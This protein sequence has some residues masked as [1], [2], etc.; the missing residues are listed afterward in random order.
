MTSF[1]NTITPSTFHGPV[2]LQQIPYASYRS[3]GIDL[4]KAYI[5][6]GGWTAYQ[7]DPVNAQTRFSK[8]KTLAPLEGL[9]INCFGQNINAVTYFCYSKSALR[10]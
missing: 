3:G 8:N 6:K 1:S 9:I 10:T 4:Y 2:V 7:V 5:R